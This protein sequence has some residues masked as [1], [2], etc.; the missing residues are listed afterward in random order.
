MS[1]RNAI[2]RPIIGMALVSPAFLLVAAFVLFP[3]G[4]AIF[5][6][7]TNWPLIGPYH[8]VGVKNYTNIAHDSVFQQSVAPNTLVQPGTQ[9]TIAVFP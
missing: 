8:Y 3:L 4:F 1:R 9:I 5:I 7:F 6:S 2:R